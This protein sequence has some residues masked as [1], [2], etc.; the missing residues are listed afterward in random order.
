[1][2]KKF[3]SEEITSINGISTFLEGD[4]CIFAKSVLGENIVVSMEN[5]KNPDETGY[6]RFANGILTLVLRDNDLH[7][8]EIPYRSLWGVAAVPVVVNEH[9]TS[10]TPQ[11]S[12]ALG[13]AILVKGTDV[14][15]TS[16]EFSE[17]AFIC[18]VGNVWDCT[19]IRK[20]RKSSYNF[21]IV[22]LDNTAGFNFI[23]TNGS[24]ELTLPNGNKINKSIAKIEEELN[25]YFTREN[26]RIEND[27]F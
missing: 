14:I 15:T 18:K 26:K 27:D 6:K 23:V 3:K 5:R 11:S 13:R 19:F 16:R 25:D 10:K 2:A 24:V 20:D 1:M 17:S 8:R 4:I 12:F 22:G 21:A 7:V 9:V